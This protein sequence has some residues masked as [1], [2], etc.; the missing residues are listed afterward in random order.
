MQK[1]IPFFPYSL[2]LKTWTNIEFEVILSYQKKKKKE[3]Q[4]IHH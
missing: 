2:F 1:C 3:K 4:I